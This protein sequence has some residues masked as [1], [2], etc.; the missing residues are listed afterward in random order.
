MSKRN[1]RVSWEL[2]ESGASLMIGLKW[3]FH[4]LVSCNPLFLCQMRIIGDVFVNWIC[5]FNRPFAVGGHVTSTTLNQSAMTTWHPEM[6][7]AGWHYQ[8]GKVLTI[9]FKYVKNGKQQIIGY[10]LRIYMTGEQGL[11]SSTIF[12]FISL[13][14]IWFYICC[15]FWS[16]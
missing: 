11:L 2:I 13:E 7:R 15:H 1:S 16:T 5:L 10:F 8:K 9:D 14:K 6:E 4:M 12:T 3:C